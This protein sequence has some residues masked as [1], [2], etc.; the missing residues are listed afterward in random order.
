MSHSREWMEGHQ[1]PLYLSRRGNPS[2][3]FS[4]I[5]KFMLKVIQ[6]PEDDITTVS[7][8][9]KISKDN[10]QEL[11]DLT[12]GEEFRD[13]QYTDISSLE[14][15]QLKELALSIALDRRPGDTPDSVGRDE[16]RRIVYKMIQGEKHLSGE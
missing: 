11:K 9:F 6:M 12:E 7:E 2:S 3:R 4:L 8:Q 15:N 1:F 16:W 5:F 13:L 10:L 14:V